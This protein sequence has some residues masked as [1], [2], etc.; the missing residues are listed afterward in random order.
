MGSRTND[1]PVT[2]PY[3]QTKFSDDPSAF[4][5]KDARYG[6]WSWLKKHKYG[7]FLGKYF[8]SRPIYPLKNKLLV[9]NKPILLPL[10]FS[11]LYKNL[12]IYL[13]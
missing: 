11:R 7:D 8:F 1:P 3:D 9:E 13:I 4:T 2:F 5:E 6:G 12:L 10:V